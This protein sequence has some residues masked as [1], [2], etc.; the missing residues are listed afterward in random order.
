MTR[1]LQGEVN[2]RVDKA[3]LSIGKKQRFR[4]FG[5]RTKM[6]LLKEG[7]TDEN[8]GCTRINHC[9]GWNVTNN[10]IKVEKRRM[11]KIRTHGVDLVREIGRVQQGLGVF[12]GKD[13]RE[14]N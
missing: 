1:D 4:C 10:D 13:R 8:R 7:G 5:N 2:L 12:S 14:I 6:V 3:G 11:T 9:S